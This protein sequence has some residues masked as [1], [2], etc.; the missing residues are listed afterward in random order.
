MELAYLGIGI[1]IAY[2]LYKVYMKVYPNDPLL[3]KDK[4]E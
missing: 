1:I 3:P 4:K 2:I